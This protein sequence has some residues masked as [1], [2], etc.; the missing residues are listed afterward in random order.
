VTLLPELS[1]KTA[2]QIADQIHAQRRPGDLVVASIHWGGNWAYE[3]PRGQREFAHQLSML[4]PS[5]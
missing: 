3:I 1:N 5:T 2:P 4:D